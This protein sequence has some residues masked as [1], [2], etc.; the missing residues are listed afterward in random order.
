MQRRNEHTMTL[1]RTH[2]AIERAITH[3]VTRPRTNTAY[4]HAHIAGWPKMT[5]KNDKSKSGTRPVPR[6]VNRTGRDMRRRNT[7]FEVKRK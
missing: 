1:A 2:T 5:G 4:T 7:E 6:E 3:N